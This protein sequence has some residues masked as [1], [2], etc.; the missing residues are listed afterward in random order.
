MFI[1]SNTD[2]S[3]PIGNIVLPG[4]LQIPLMPKASLYSH[5]EAGAAVSAGATRW[6]PGISG[7]GDRYAPVRPAVEEEDQDIDNRFN[8]DLLAGRLAGATHWA[9]NT[10][11]FLMVFRAS[12]G[13]ASALQAAAALPET[14]PLY[15]AAD[16]PTS[17]PVHCRL[18]NHLPCLLWA[19]WMT[20]S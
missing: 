2:I 12:T 16:D 8:I 9:K 19:G 1:N 6:W 10:R 7:N 13:A 15:P 17:Q 18:F 11:A 3:I 20:K 14:K 4:I 5:T